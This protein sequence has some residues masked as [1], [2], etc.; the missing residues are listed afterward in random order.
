MLFFVA[1]L[2]HAQLLAQDDSFGIPFGQPLLVEAL[3]VLNNDTLDGETDI[4]LTAELVTPVTN[5]TL[6]C[7]DVAPGLCAD[8]SFQYIPGPGFSGTASFTYQALD[9]ATPSAAATVTLT[10]CAEV[11]PLIFSCWLESSYRAKLTELGYST[12]LESFEGS[13][14]DSVRSTFD[15]INSAP[16]ITSQGITW[17]S[18]HPLDT[19]ITTGAGPALTGSWGAYDPSHGFATGSTTECD[20]DTPPPNCLYHDGLSGKIAPGGDLG[21]DKLRG[22]GGY[23]T[24]TTG[25]NIAIILDGTTQVNVGALPDPGFHFFGLIDGTLSGFNGYEFRELDG[26]IGQ[27]RYI[28]GDDFIIA[29]TSPPQNTLAM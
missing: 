15:T 14:W 4:G 23:I 5:G 16:E 3:G 24:G 19:T 28:F 1:D 10:D 26:K 25:A 11:S 27:A 12:F 29:T 2:A 8:G 7:P 13:V 22:V 18:N 17:T 9:G 6:T 21:G 20:V